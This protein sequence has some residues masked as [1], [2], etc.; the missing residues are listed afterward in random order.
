MLRELWTLWKERRENPL[1]AYHDP[2]RRNMAGLAFRLGEIYVLLSLL[3]FVLTIVFNVEWY[4]VRRGGWNPSLAMVV[5]GL[6]VAIPTFFLGVAPGPWSRERSIDLVLTR[7]SAREIAFGYL[8]WPLLLLT[9]MGIS[10]GLLLATFNIDFLGSPP[11]WSALLILIYTLVG[12]GLTFSIGM[13]TL[14][15]WYK[16]SA[17]RW[18]ALAVAPVR[19]GLGIAC[20][21]L[22]LEMAPRWLSRNDW[23]YPALAL[24][25]VL[26]GAGRASIALSAA[27]WRILG[28]ASCPEGVLH[29]HWRT[30]ER[31]FSLLSGKG[32]DAVHRFL[33][34][35]IIPVTGFTL[36]VCF[37]ALAGGVMGFFLTATSIDPFG[38]GIARRLNQLEQAAFAAG[39]MIMSLP[40]GVALATWIISLWNSGR[41]PMLSGRVFLGSLVYTL[42]TAVLFALGLIQ[43]GAARGLLLMSDFHRICGLTTLVVFMLSRFLLLLMIPRKGRLAM[44]ALLCLAS[45]SVATQIDQMLAELIFTSLGL[46]TLCFVFGVAAYLLLEW[47][48]FRVHRLELADVP[49]GRMNIDPKTDEPIAS[50]ALLDELAAKG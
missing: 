22:V 7:L 47:A 31:A 39:M 44:T 15:H 50:E 3:V 41:I 11:L 21:Y 16:N 18:A 24:L 35:A 26:W 9:A 13:F 46:P 12:L 27:G 42:P 1:I 40:F 45:Y 38:T 17:W 30:R 20:M 14:E 37:V 10:T 2:R 8:F 43:F 19:F 6:A 34:S 32:R 36:V 49:L 28:V 4:Y 48:H 33:I 5:W 23:P 25:L 29:S